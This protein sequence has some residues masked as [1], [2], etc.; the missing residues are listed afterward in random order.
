MLQNLLTSDTT[1]FALL[2][3][4]AVGQ[5][6]LD[7]PELLWK[8]YID[9]EI[10]EEEFDNVR[11]LYARLLER[12]LAFG[13]CH[14]KC[15]ACACYF[16]ARF[17]LIG[18][19][20]SRC[21]VGTKHVK[22]WISMAQFES[23]A[24]EVG[25]ARDVFVKANAHFKA[26]GADHKEERVLLLE[27]WR[28][29]EGSFGD[30]S[31]QEAPAKLMPRRVKRKR[32]ITAEDGSDGGASFETTCFTAQLCLLHVVL[33]IADDDRSFLRFVRTS[34]CVR[35]H[36]L[37]GVLRLYLPRRGAGV[38]QPQDLGDGSQ[39][40]EGE[41][42]GRLGET[43]SEP[44]CLP[45]HHCP[46]EL[47]LIRTAAA[48]GCWP[49]AVCRVAGGVGYA[50]GRLHVLLAADQVMQMQVFALLAIKATF[51]DYVAE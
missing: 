41:N 21:D 11:T 14:C 1:A 2:R 46:V 30:T 17:I 7:M 33:S 27:S 51:Q 47:V 24:G 20:C 22:V 26:A 5:S 40:E 16:S 44:A 4:T 37:G 45:C 50:V 8:A 29:F 12:K 35:V 38:S 36:R 49:S 25:N 13:N 28:D 19:L 10:A 48:D 3:T 43:A 23:A 34:I 42:I 9:F 15:A 6:L 31:Q 39:V 18:R 32:A